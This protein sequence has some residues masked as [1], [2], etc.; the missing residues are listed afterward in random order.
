MH[1]PLYFTVTQGLGPLHFQDHRGGRR[2][3]SFLEERLFRDNQVY[4]HLFDTAD[5]RD[6]TSQFTLQGTL[7]VQLLHKLGHA[8]V[9]TIKDLKADP[10][11]LG[12]P[13]GSQRESELM[14]TV[15]R[16]HYPF[17]IRADLV[18]GFGIFQF[19]DNLPGVF[20]VQ[21]GE[22][23]PIFGAICQHDQQG[24]GHDAGSHH[25]AD[26]QTLTE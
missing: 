7:V 16:H 20:T 11:P 14:H 15:C 4:T 1:H 19:L 17:T 3:F 23:R 21:I 18:G 22:E 10:A 26:K 13:L 25:P 24:K 2:L 12:Q 8:E 9:F 6:S 5:L